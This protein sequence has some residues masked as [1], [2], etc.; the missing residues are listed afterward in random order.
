[1]DLLSL[2]YSYTDTETI[3]AIMEE[4]LGTWASII[5]P[6][7]QKTIREFQNAVKYHE[8]SLEKL[9]PPVSQPS[10]LPNREYSRSRFPYRKANV[11]L[12]GWSKNIGTPQF[13]KDDKNMSPR[14]IPESIGARPCRHCGSG[15]HWDNECHH[16]RKGEKLARVNY[17]RLENND[18]RTQEDYDNLFYE[19]DSNSEQESSSQDF[20]RPL[21]H[22]DLPAQLNSPN[23]EKLKDVSSLEGTKGSFESLGLETT[24]SADLN[25]Y[26]TTSHKI[27]TLPETSSILF[28]NSL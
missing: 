20:C 28:I 7:Y 11:N 15:N 22:S 12:V 9:E 3:Q 23:S 17:I 6:Q 14:R 24:Q 10:R 8:E 16:S 13:P 5:N 19:L 1:M 25:S 27:T 4:V 26:S 21:Q 18:I 2:V